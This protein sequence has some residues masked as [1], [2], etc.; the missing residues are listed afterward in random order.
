VDSAYESRIEIFVVNVM[1]TFPSSSF[2]VVG[3]V[4]SVY[5]GPAGARTPVRTSE[6][7][8]KVVTESMSSVAARFS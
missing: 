1:T 8:N 4:P 5:E 7:R 2:S 6:A 3:D